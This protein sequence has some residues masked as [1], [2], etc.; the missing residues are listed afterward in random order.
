[1]V[2]DELFSKRNE[3][4]QSLDL[5]KVKTLGY[6]HDIGKMVGPFK[7]HVM[8]LMVFDELFSKR[9]ITWNSSGSTHNII[10]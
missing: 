7:N 1:M 6:I 2:F 8:V 10:I 4:G 9:N 5:D 3:K